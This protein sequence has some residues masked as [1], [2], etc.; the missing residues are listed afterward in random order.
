M[1]VDEVSYVAQFCDFSTLVNI[2]K[3]DE[4]YKHLCESDDSLNHILEEDNI[5]AFSKYIEMYNP[6]IKDNNHVYHCKSPITFKYFYEKGH[7]VNKIYRKCIDDGNV[8]LFNFMFN[9]LDLPCTKGTFFTKACYESQAEIATIILNACSGKISFEPMMYFRYSP[10]ILSMISDNI[11]KFTKDDFNTMFYC[12]HDMNDPSNDLVLKYAA[13]IF[14]KCNLMLR[15]TIPIELVKVIVERHDDK[16]VFLTRLLDIAVYEDYILEILK[17]SDSYG[18]EYRTSKFISKGYNSVIK[19]I[20]NETNHDLIYNPIDIYLFSYETL[21]ELANTKR[22]YKT[23]ILTQ[24]LYNNKFLEIFNS[25]PFKQECSYVFYE[26]NWK[27]MECS[28]IEKLPTIRE[29]T[30]PQIISDGYG[31]PCPIPRG[32]GYPTK[33]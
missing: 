23:D 7:D 11:D 28:D 30:Y 16:R 32:Y 26:T 21:R 19:Y 33:L 29:Y 4:E 5:E 27:A 9:T 12:S 22:L 6:K 24:R 8:R 31:Y 2:M 20:I 14:C 1:N 25:I 18:I 17:I 15:G 10:E 13:D 3:V